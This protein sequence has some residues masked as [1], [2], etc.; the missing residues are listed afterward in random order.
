[1][2]QGALFEDDLRRV[3]ACGHE[4]AHHSGRNACTYGAG[5]RFGGCACK[6]LRP[7][8]RRPVPVAP[9]LEAPIGA[10]ELVR[11]DLQRRKVMG[12]ATVYEKIVTVYLS[13][14]KLKSPNV[15]NRIWGAHVS[16]SMQARIIAGM[17]AERKRQCELAASAIEQCKVLD[18]GHPSRVVLSRISTGRLDD[19]NLI[20]SCKAIRDG[21]AEALLVDDREFSILGQPGMIPI[22]YRQESPGKR[23]VY[24]VRT[25]LQWAP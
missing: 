12:W 16:K 25:T 24:G 11:P 13:Q 1:M 3:C 5:L 18:R 14:L 9:A 22:E 23:G 4:A 15:A 10:I 7:R 17:A 19:D 8:G 20:A 6:R 2:T 21:V